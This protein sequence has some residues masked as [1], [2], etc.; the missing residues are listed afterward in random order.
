MKLRTSTE[1][2]YPPAPWLLRGDAIVGFRS[3]SIAATRHLVPSTLHAQMISPG[4]TLAIV[5]LIR[6][7]AE[8]TLQY[9]EL[10]IAPTLVRAGG[11]IGALISHIY[12]DSQASLEGGRQIWGLPKQLAAFDWRDDQISVRAQ[13]LHMQLY[14]ISPLH[15]S[16]NWRLPVF[17]PAFGAHSSTLKWMVARGSG[18]LSRVHGRITCRALDIETLELQKISRFLRITQ[19]SLRFPVPR[20]LAPPNGALSA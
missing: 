10:I 3:V 2:P 11:R 6:Y 18:C 15:T 12:V 7:G 13:N 9:N 8:S 5:A 20:S 1:I 17:A 16:L 4:H 14:E 19:F